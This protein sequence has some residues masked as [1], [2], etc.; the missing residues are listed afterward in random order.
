MN[1]CAD[2]SRRR[3]DATI[4]HGWTTHGQARPIN[5]GLRRPTL[6][7]DGLEGRRGYPR[8]PARQTSENTEPLAPQMG[9]FSGGSPNSMWPHTGQR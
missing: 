3:A 2:C 4:P 8:G 1:T 9:H 7:G 5:A 6:P